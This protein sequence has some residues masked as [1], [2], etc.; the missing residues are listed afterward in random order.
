MERPSARVSLRK[1]LNKFYLVID[2][3]K[4]CVIF[5]LFCNYGKLVTL[6]ECYGARSENKDTNGSL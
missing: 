4:M 3:S 2:F 5:N 1:S 6:L